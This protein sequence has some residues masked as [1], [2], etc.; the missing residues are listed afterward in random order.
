MAR[1]LLTSKG[2]EAA[3]KRAQA[4]AAARQTRA[5]IRDGDN[6]I[7]I[8]RPNGG[9]SWVLQYRAGGKRLPLTLGAWPDVSLKLARELADRAR[10]AAALRWRRRSA[11]V[12]LR[13]LCEWC[14]AWRGSPWPP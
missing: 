10:Q 4:D 6:L 13:W 2:L 5:K 3:L 7:L 11:W 14:A 9:A 12:R 8:V 1:E